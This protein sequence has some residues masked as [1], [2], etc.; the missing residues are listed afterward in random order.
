M[1]EDLINIFTLIGQLFT[2]FVLFCMFCLVIFGMFV[3]WEFRQKH[4]KNR[5]GKHQSAGTIT[6]AKPETMAA[7]IS[8][9]DE[10]EARIKRSDDLD[11]LRQAANRGEFPVPYISTWEQEGRVTRDKTE[12]LPFNTTGKGV[13][14]VVHPR[15]T[16]H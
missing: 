3:L 16:S 9:L 4:Q 2:L 7:F 13:T 10:T 15:F 14:D 5:Y 1:F 6:D 11:K 12:I 8:M